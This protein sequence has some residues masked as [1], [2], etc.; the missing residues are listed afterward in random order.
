MTDNNSVENKIRQQAVDWTRELLIQPGAVVSKTLIEKKTGTLT[1]FA[2][3]QGQTLSEHSAPFD[4]FVHL[5]SGQMKISLNGKPIEI[6]QGGSLI[7]PA[8]IP[9]ALE[10]LRPSHML[11][12]MIRS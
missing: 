5:L 8:D 6:N 12:V 1:L 2:F 11:L 10:A 7:M 4:A 3:D 9:H